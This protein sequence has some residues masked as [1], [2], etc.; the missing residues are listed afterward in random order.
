VGVDGSTGSDHAVRW[1]ATY[2]AAQR[3]PLGIVHGA[4]APE[5]LVADFHV[6]LVQA[7]RGLLRKG[8]MVTDRARAL[9]CSITPSL[10]VRTR[11]EACDP[12]LLLAEEAS[13]AHLM[14]LGSRGH[15]AVTSLY[16]GS[17]SVALAAHALCP[18]VVVRPAGDDDTSLPVVVGVD[19]VE[20]STSALIF[21]FELAADQR[22]P[23][24][25][26]HAAGPARLSPALETADGVAADMAGAM[27]GEVAADAGLLL[28]EWV[29]GYAEKFPDV[30]VTCEVV[31]G[32]APGALVAAS[33][34][35]STVVVGARGC[36]ALTERLLG[37][38]S[39]SVVE[40]AC[41]TVAV[42]RGAQR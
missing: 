20:D 38:V 1:A 28:V 31:Q 13:E 14:V 19:G 18:V 22:R 8:R 32:S 30:S 10:K 7:R 11:L 23:L 4:G 42:I 41:C 16:P 24:Q 40:Q 36:S 27:A 26:V 25:V 15:G 37:S 33:K 6:D 17:V 29:A 9:A 39:R 34:H 3:R 12:R 5:S 35:A 2:A 21:A